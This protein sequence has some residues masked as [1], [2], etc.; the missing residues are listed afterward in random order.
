MRRRAT[1]LQVIVTN[2]RHMA[3][4]QMIRVYARIYPPSTSLP[5]RSS[6]DSSGAGKGLACLF[7]FHGLLALL[8]FWLLTTTAAITPH[9]KGIPLLKQLECSR[10]EACRRYWRSTEG[11]KGHRRTAFSRTIRTIQDCL[12]TAG[13][14]CPAT[15]SCRTLHVPGIS[16]L[17]WTNNHNEMSVAA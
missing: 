8:A 9:F 16:S 7:G 2:R 10:E 1:N 6:A 15:F 17:N 4:R 5:G 13:L 3:N 14:A 11:R 12:H